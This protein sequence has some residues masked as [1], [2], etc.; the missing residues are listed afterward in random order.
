MDH[1][2]IRRVVTG[3][4]EAGNAI[5][6]SDKQLVVYNPL[7][8]TLDESTS[9]KLG[10]ATIWRTETYPAKADG[11]WQEINGI[12]IPLHH[13]IG[14]TVRIVDFA[15]DPGLRHRTHTVDFGMVLFGEIELELDNGVKTVMRQGDTVI[16]RATIHA[17][18]NHG[19]GLARMLFFLMPAE[20]VVRGGVPMEEEGIPPQ[21][22][23]GNQ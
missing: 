10:F 21:L 1:P 18:V 7:S 13:D 22:E 15:P 12:Q 14:N 16:Q 5:I 2:P 6:E 8:P 19:P 9:G 20:P 3:H 4:N 23:E 17:W 11:P